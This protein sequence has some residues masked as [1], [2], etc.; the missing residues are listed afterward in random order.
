MAPCAR[1]RLLGTRKRAEEVPES[2]LAGAM[3]CFGRRVVHGLSPILGLP[4]I[5]TTF[6]APRL[7][8]PLALWCQFWAMA[9][10]F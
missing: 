6:K 4:V 8:I 10:S 5:P 3:A 9:C 1:E 2:L 7:S